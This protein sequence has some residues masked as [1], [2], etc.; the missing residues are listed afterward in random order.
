MKFNLIF[1]VFI[2]S[3]GLPTFA[4]SSGACKKLA[5][6]C[7]A[8]N[9][10]PRSHET[11]KDLFQDCIEP[12]MEQKSVPGVTPDKKIIDACKTEHALNFKKDETHK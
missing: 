11:K 7:R 2:A 12:L 4:D 3:C 6:A 1:L 10:K 5:D 8:A 9:F